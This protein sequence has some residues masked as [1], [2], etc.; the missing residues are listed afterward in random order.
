MDRNCEHPKRNYAEYCGETDANATNKTTALT[1][2]KTRTG[3]NAFLGRMRLKVASDA[4]C[5]IWESGPRQSGPNS[6]GKTFIDL[7]ST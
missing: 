1:K 6:N 7:S 3:S 5:G 4:F 2:N